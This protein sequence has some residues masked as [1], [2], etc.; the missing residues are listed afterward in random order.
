[1]NIFNKK[2]FLIADIGFKF[3]DIAKQEG[4]SNLDAA[5]LMIGEAKKSGVDAVSFYSFKA[6]NIFSQNN[7][8]EMNWITNSFDFQLDFFKR[9][10]E[11]G[12]DE[13]KQLSEFCKELGILL[14]F[15]PLDFESVELLDELM[16]ICII[17]SSNLDNNSFIRYVASKNRSILLLTGGATMREIKEA[18]KTIEDSS[19]CDIAIL[20]CVLSYPTEYSDANLL[21]IKDLKYQFP[22]YEIGYVDYT[23]PD[24]YLVLLTTAYN[25][26]ADV[27]IKPFTLDKTLNNHEYSMDS[28][29]IAKFKENIKFLSKINGYSNKQPLICESSA[30]KAYRKSIVAKKDI[31]KDDVISDDDIAFKSPALGI[32]PNEVDLILGKHAAIDIS[33][34]DIIGYDMLKD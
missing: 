2:P 9:F 6:E 1:M 7:S 8:V 15:N 17:S 16:D 18:V 5:K 12:Y 29:D 31:K 33:K 4:I 23:K 11:F 34:D 30:L 20:H 32:S 21:M 24:E 25:Y 26:G 3:F 22:N 19:T 28:E 13:F 14:L 10:D 27:L